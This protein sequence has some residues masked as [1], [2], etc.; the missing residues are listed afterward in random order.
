M[1]IYSKHHYL[2]V[3]F[4]SCVSICFN[5]VYLVFVLGLRELLLKEQDIAGR[6]CSI[7]WILCEI[8]PTCPRNG[9][10]SQFKFQKGQN[11]I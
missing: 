10:P 6:I 4:S 7:K 8:L 3:E 1:I 5:V 9:Q 2:G 11:M